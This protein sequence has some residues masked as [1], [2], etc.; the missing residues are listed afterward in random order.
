MRNL[1]TTGSIIVILSEAKNLLRFS[2]PAHSQDSRGFFTSLRSVQN[3]KYRTTVNNTSRT[4][5]IATCFT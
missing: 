3:D 1:S 2:P 4:K 5:L